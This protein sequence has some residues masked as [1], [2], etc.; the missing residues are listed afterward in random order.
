M[1]RFL[2]SRRYANLLFTIGKHKNLHALSKETDMT[3]SHLSNVT[4]QWVR[5]GLIKKTRSG[6]EVDVEITAKGQKLVELTRK[7]DDLFHDK[8]E[9]KNEG[10]NKEVQSD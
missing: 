6:R 3:I 9:V 2:M 8:K 10:Q 7:F 4:D 1:Y 5:E